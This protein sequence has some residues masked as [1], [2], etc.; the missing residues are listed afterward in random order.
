MKTYLIEPMDAVIV[1]DGRPFNNESSLSA[2]TLP[3]PMPSTTTGAFRTRI[4]L[5]ENKKFD[6]DFVS[7]LK[8]TS[9]SGPLLVSADESGKFSRYYVAPPAD[10]VLFDYGSGDVR[11]GQDHVNVRPLTPLNV[12]E[13]VLYDPFRSGSGSENDLTLVGLS[14]N[15]SSLEKPSK[16]AP[17]FWKFETFVRWLKDPEEVS[18]QS[19][20]VS[21][22]GITRLSEN[23]RVHVKIDP[24]TGMSEDSKLFET[25]G[26]EFLKTGSGDELLTN[27]GRFALAVFSDYA[28]EKFDGYSGFGAERRIVR[29]S[30]SETGPGECPAE[31]IND[32]K[33]SK[34]CRLI[35]LTP[36]CFRDGYIPSVS[37]LE[38]PGISSEKDSARSPLGIS[39]IAAC[40]KRP[41]TVSGWDMEKGKPKPTR[42]LAPAGS[43]YFLKFENASDNEIED[44]IKEI[45]FSCISDDI[46]DKTDGFGLCAVGTWSGHPESLT[47]E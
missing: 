21:D 13:N 26:L 43:V 15:N 32:I 20:P 28:S 29:W 14:K 16:K 46:Q 34:A 18:S 3:F 8:S 9:V 40:V 6:P 25:K 17:F 11:S 33:K 39:V 23:I 36:A 10:A 41:V 37:S 31:I 44:W 22:I 12:P 38:D 4:G 30:S 19:V 35:L 2:S 7:F 1:R 27:T 5:T 47:E 24:E 45:W 42:R